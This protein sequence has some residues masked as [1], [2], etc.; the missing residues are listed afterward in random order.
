MTDAPDYPLLSAP[1]DGVPDLIVDERALQRAADAI[2]AGSGPVA[3]DAE[4][5]SGF[6]YG[7]RAY[8]VQLRREGVGNFLIDPIACPDLT[9]LNDAIGDAEWVLHA[10]TQ[11]LPCLAEVGL[12]PVRLFDTELGSRLAG[13]PRVGLAS[14]VEHYLGVTL[15]KEHSAVDWSERPLPQPWL[16]YATLDVELLVPVRDHLAADLEAQG[17]TEIAAQEFDALTRFTGPPQRTDPWRRTGGMHKVRGRRAIARVREL[18]LARDAIAAHRD[19]APG[20]VLPDALL[21]EMAVADPKNS[22]ELLA[23]RQQN[24]RSGRPHPSLGRYQRDWLSAL[25]R[26]RALPEA[27][28]PPATVRS[29]A[30][31]PPKAWA[32]RHPVAAARLTD[33]RAALQRESEERGI[34]VENLLTPDSLRRVLWEA[35]ET[36]EPQ[37]FSD[38]LVAL[39]ARPWQVDLALPILTRTVADHPATDE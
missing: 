33:A 3:L 13:L 36:V 30:P 35:P 7:G 34:P 17:K 32:D 20:R 38:R 31:P 15:A 1:A 25:H 6:R 4:R 21:V 10:A 39:G 27:Q 37:W 19:I 23:L 8:L 18:W 29:D 26:V 14:V 24:S 11:D 28:L 5:A 2:A 22:G 12:R 9:P 16:V